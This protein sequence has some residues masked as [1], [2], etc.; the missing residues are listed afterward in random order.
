MFSSTIRWQ[1]VKPYAGFM[2][3]IEFEAVVIRIDDHEHWFKRRV[4]MLEGPPVTITLKPERFV[5]LHGE[6]TATITYSN[7]LDEPLTGVELTFDGRS[8]LLLN[9]SEKEEE[10]SI[11][12]IPA[13]SMAT[14]VRT[15]I[16]NEIGEG[17]FVAILYTK[18]AERVDAFRTVKITCPPDLN[19]D[20]AIDHLDSDE[21]L[22]AFGTNMP[23]ADFNKDGVVNATDYVDFM[24][25]FANG[26]S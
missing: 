10:I 22:V 11:G 20:T 16:A 23:P 17:S 14:F 26:C 1:D 25:A 13:K 6:V 9:G 19:G 5:A 2:P 21:F 7:P 4:L 8:N 3:F 15:L 18:N 12:T 24:V